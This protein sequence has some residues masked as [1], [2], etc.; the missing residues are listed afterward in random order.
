MPVGQPPPSQPFLALLIAVVLFAIGRVFIRRV[1]KSQGGDP[2]LAKALLVC[3]ILHLIF[4]PLQIWVVDHLYGGIADYTR[5][6]SQGTVLAQGFRHFNF[7]L[8]PANL[9]GIVGDGAV[10]IVAGVVFAIIGANQAGAFLVFS[11]LSF[12]G[13]AYF[14]RAFTLTFS[15]AGNRRYGYLVFFLPT[16]LFWT[17]DVSKEAIMVFL[18]GLTAYGCALALAYRGRGYFLIIACSVGGAFIRPNETLL[19]LGG[20]TV[21][22]LCR[23]ASPKSRFNGPRRTLSVI[24]LGALTGVAIFVTLHY[25]PGSSNGLSLTSI[26]KNNSGTGNGFGSGGIG[27]SANPLY[28]PKDVFVVLFDPLPFNAHGAGEYFEALENTLMVG[29][30]LTSLRG[31]RILPRV[32]FARPYV[33]MCLIFTGAFCYSFA[34]LGNLGLITREVVVAVPFFLVVV[35]IPRGP[36]RRPPRYVWELR[37]RDRVARRKALTRRPGARTAGRAV[38]I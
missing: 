14:Y 33:L 2:W 34:S 31:L 16:L 23:P 35:S 30:V 28:F 38:P 27:Y 7:S 22:M 21:A 20:F 29:V 13:V 5:Y 19:A 9:R 37:R 11:F 3:L 10:S 18:L 32:C 12:I 36:R 26:S 6:D 15:G 4:A 17:S 8:A 24:F 1:V 25:L